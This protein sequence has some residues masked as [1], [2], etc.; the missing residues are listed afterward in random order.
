[1]VVVVVLKEANQ[2]SSVQFS[3]VQLATSG[4]S[5]GHWVWLIEPSRKEHDTIGKGSCHMSS[6]LQT[7]PSSSSSPSPPPT[8]QVAG[9]VPVSS[10]PLQSSPSP[11]QTTPTKTGNG[12]GSGSGNGNSSRQS[13]FRTTTAATTTTISTSTSSPTSSAQLQQKNFV[14]R[15]DL[16]SYG[17]PKSNLLRLNF[18]FKGLG[19]TQWLGVGL[20]IFCGILVVFSTPVAF[21]P[22]SLRLAVGIG[23][24]AVLLVILFAPLVSNMTLLQA[25]IQRRRFNAS[26]IGKRTRSRLPR[27][28]G[29]GRSS[30]KASQTT[31]QL[32]KLRA[33]TV[34]LDATDAE[35]EDKQTELTTRARQRQKELERQAKAEKDKH[36]PHTDEVLPFFGLDNHCFSLRSGSGAGGA[37]CLIEVGGLNYLDENASTLHNFATNLATATQLV[38]LSGGQ[39]NDGVA[40]RFCVHQARLDTS[41]IVASQIA[42]SNYTNEP[43]LAMVANWDA[44]HFQSMQ[45][46]VTSSG[47]VSGLAHRRYYVALVLTEKAY[48]VEQ[49]AAIVEQQ[50]EDVLRL[51]EEFDQEGEDDEDAARLESEMYARAR[52]SLLDNLRSVIGE[53]LESFKTDFLGR[54]G[55]GVDDMGATGTNKGKGKGKGKDNKRRKSNSLATDDAAATANLAEQEPETDEE[56]ESEG[57][58]EGAYFGGMPIPAGASIR[59][60]P[61]PPALAETLHR[62]AEIIMGSL[63]QFGLDPR[64]LMNHEAARVAASMLGMPAGED[65]FPDP[66]NTRQARAARRER[67]RRRESEKQQEQARRREQDKRAKRGLGLSVADQDHLA[68]RLQRIV[69]SESLSGGTGSDNSTTGKVS[70]IWEQDANADAEDDFGATGEGDGEGEGNGRKVEPIDGSAFGLAKFEFDRH[71]VKVGSVRRYGTPSPTYFGSIYVQE[72]P[73]EVRLGQLVNIL[74]QADLDFIMTVHIAPVPPRKAMRKL[75]RQSQQQDNLEDLLETMGGNKS[76]QERREQYQQRAELERMQEH[77]AGGDTSLMRVTLRIAVK[78]HS[79]IRL[80]TGIRVVLS[81]LTAAGFTAYEAQYNQYF[82]LMS[83]LPFGRDAIATTA[84]YGPKTV[85]L[86]TP[87]VA[88][89]LFPALIP[90]EASPDGVIL[91]TSSAGGLIRFSTKMGV[92][93]HMAIFGMSGSGKTVSNMG[94]ITR[95]LN[96]DPKTKACIVD[97]QDVTYEPVLA[98]GGE[99]VKV[100]SDGRFCINMLDRS[101][102]GLPTSI[103]DLGETLKNFLILMR[104]AALSVMEDT[105]LQFAL[106][107]LYNHFEMG[108]PL[109]ETLMLGLYNR[110]HETAG[111]KDNDRYKAL[112][113]Y[114]QSLYAEFGQQYRLPETG[115]VVSPVYNPETGR[116]YVYDGRSKQFVDDYDT[117]DFEKRNANNYKIGVRLRVWLTKTD[118]LGRNV[119]SGGGY[120]FVEIPFGAYR[121][122]V[123]EVDKKNFAEQQRLATINYFLLCYLSEP[124]KIRWEAA[125]EP[126]TKIDWVV[127]AWVLDEVQAAEA[128]RQEEE[129]E[130]GKQDEEVKLEPKLRAK[131]AALP[132]VGATLSPRGGAFIYYEPTWWKMVETNFKRRLRSFE[133]EYEYE[134]ELE[135]EYEGGGYGSLR[136]VEN[137]WQN[138]DELHMSRI[139]RDCFVGLKRGVPILSDLVGVLYHEQLCMPL[140][141]TIEPY[142]EPTLNGPLFNGHTNFDV[143][144]RLFSFCL[145][146]ATGDLL[147]LRIMQSIEIIWKR[148]VNQPAGETTILFWDEYGSLVM[149]R[150]ELAD[151]VQM[152]FKRARAFGA[153]LI[154]AEQSYSLVKSTAASKAIDNC[155]TI[156]LLLQSEQAAVMAGYDLSLTQKEVEW[157]KSAPMGNAMFVIKQNGRNRKFTARHDL[158]PRLIKILSTKP[159]DRARREQE[160]EERSGKLTSNEVVKL[161]KKFG[162]RSYS[163]AA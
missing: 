1:M 155:G 29:Q 80:K 23:L 157:L 47:G 75:E 131:L 16:P 100:G 97:I 120:R 54:D 64:L 69:T 42:A 159:E 144:N 62:K 111:L 52:G 113:G 85:R 163:D 123:A 142:V 128:L 5:S 129:S 32:S 19:I 9:S 151:Y 63:S 135:V 50:M 141:E 44:Q 31:R 3:S 88:A 39:P 110:Y 2:F 45:N 126:G 55:G 56:S 102:M 10:Q 115:Y 67:A 125:L 7:P 149:L 46:I 158:P 58:G 61:V 14:V 130:G 20:A 60:N 150:P 68:E 78:A 106:V 73:R 146:N 48:R 40:V 90:E 103:A 77:L 30:A 53:N 37:A 83:A 70:R 148:I 26:R 117:P 71:Y 24:G 119:Y 76:R 22:L 17:V 49:Q 132:L 98:L 94:Y 107:R 116:L 86:V 35:I 95:S 114:V 36:L 99:A 140:A 92:S 122:I 6:A 93:P 160:R 25:A 38:A 79:P 34:G 154:L 109:T 136:Q 72:W 138:V 105:K 28:R 145:K 8:A 21:L 89:C 41:E 152:Q 59:N 87:E 57:E 139:E 91:G 43:G 112:Y 101:A 12:S 118:N 133:Y 74:G 65:I 96:A 104:K 15:Q 84:G 143:G 51:R 121:G 33:A 162:G 13:K 27:G 153:V 137:F 81:K 147:G 66:A 124:D 11:S 156:Q 18:K 134:Y 82:G 4:L 127:P 161:V 108:H